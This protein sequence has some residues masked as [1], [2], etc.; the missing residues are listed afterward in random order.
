MKEWVVIERNRKGARA[1]REKGEQEF[2]YLTLNK[3]LAV[4]HI[5]KEGFLKFIFF[6]FKPRLVSITI[7]ICVA[8]LYF[9]IICTDVKYIFYHTV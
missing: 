5:V 6:I 9:T 4:L 7:F 8:L 3:N 1:G 2:K